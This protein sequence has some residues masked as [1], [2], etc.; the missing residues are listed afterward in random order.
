[1]SARQKPD[2]DLKKDLTSHCCE[3]IFCLPSISDAPGCGPGLVR[4]TRKVRWSKMLPLY[5]FKHPRSPAQQGTR[6]PLTS[7]YSKM[8]EPV[9]IEPTT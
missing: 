8:V 1:M 5:D 2:T 3:V 4:G 9:G 7:G 6:I